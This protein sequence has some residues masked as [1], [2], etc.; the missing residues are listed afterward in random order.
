MVLRSTVYDAVYFILEKPSK[1]K[2]YPTFFLILIEK[3]N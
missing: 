2:I 3:L 1:F